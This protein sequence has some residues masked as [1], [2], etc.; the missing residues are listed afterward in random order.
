MESF[1]D[2]LMHDQKQNN[3][4]KVEDVS[5]VKA[6]IVGN[7]LLKKGRTSTTSRYSRAVFIYQ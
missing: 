2:I 3:L 7:Y 6:V 5:W 4:A 1:G